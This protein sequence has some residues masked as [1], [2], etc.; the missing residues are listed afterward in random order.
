MKK[1]KKPKLL[2]KQIM[3]CPDGHEAIC[4]VYEDN[5]LNYYVCPICNM[6][7]GL[8]MDGDSNIDENI[9]G[10]KVYKKEIN[11]SMKFSGWN[12]NKIISLFRKREFKM[13]DVN[14]KKFNPISEDN[15]GNGE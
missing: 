2:F 9:I 13:I 5:G 3:N 15:R 4:N 7:V 11:K 12:C 8:M 14:C 10:C 1:I 6:Y